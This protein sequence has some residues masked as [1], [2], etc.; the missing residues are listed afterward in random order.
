MSTGLP[1]I[2]S[3]IP[4][5][6]L[7]RGATLEID[8]ATVRVDLRAASSSGSTSTRTPRTTA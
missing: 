5:S 7:A 4:R 8:G 1:P 3:E 6:L 2:G